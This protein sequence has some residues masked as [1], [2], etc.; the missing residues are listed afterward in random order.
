MPHANVFVI[1]SF[2]VIKGFGIKNAV[3]RR[4]NGPLEQFL[5]RLTAQN[6]DYSS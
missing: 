6:Y 5:T 4:N 3:S 1:S 2:K